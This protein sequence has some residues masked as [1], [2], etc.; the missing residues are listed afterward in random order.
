[1]CCLSRL[2]RGKKLATLKFKLTDDI[3]S[4]QFVQQHSVISN[5]KEKKLYSGT[6]LWK[7]FYFNV[8]LLQ[9]TTDKEEKGN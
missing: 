7:S 9:I 3:Q 6:S 5:Y 8:W 4:M 2:E 1:M